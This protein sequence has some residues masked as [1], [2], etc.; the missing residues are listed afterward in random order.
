MSSIVRCAVR[1]VGGLTGGVFGMARARSCV[2]E[3][4]TTTRGHTRR[5]IQ[6]TDSPME[7]PV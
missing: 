7:V 1:E 3:V 5:E 2:K 4:R 6:A